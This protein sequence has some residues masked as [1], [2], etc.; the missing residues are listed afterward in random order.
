MTTKS[1]TI[2]VDPLIVR[3]MCFYILSPFRI[4]AYENKQDDFI[5]DDLLF[6]VQSRDTV[7]AT[8]NEQLS[9]LIEAYPKH[10][11]YRVKIGKI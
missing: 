10:H 3:E 1:S 8:S 4:E 5:A 7:L 6:A 2:R 9:L 11:V